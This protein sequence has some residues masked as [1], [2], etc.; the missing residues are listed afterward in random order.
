MCSRI[1][2]PGVTADRASAARVIA[3]R[4]TSPSTLTAGVDPTGVRVS[5][6]KV[7]DAP[8]NAHADAFRIAEL[9]FTMA[10]RTTTFVP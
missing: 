4:W 6:A 5:A 7:T 9:P 3:A 1:V 2:D 8:A 10:E